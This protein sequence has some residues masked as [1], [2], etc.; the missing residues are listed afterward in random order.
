MFVFLPAIL[1]RESFKGWLRHR[2]LPDR[3]AALLYGRPEMAGLTRLQVTMTMMMLV[4]IM[5]TMM[6][7]MIMVTMMLVMT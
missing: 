2:P 1:I 4:M 6:L 3:R 7:V 5:V